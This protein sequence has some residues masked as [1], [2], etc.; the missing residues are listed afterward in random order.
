MNR[1]SSRSRQ[2]TIVTGEGRG[3]PAFGS[4]SGSAS[5]AVVTIAALSTFASAPLA[6]TTG[7]ASCENILTA[8]TTNAMTITPMAAARSASVIF[9]DFFERRIFLKR[10]MVFMRIEILL[11]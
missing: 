1:S 10:S 7:D 9:S 2:P 11:G 3:A 4:S 5:V 8:V 6:L